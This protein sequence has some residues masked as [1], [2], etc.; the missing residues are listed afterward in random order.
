MENE[1]E[2]GKFLHGFLLIIN[3]II[4]AG[5]AVPL[6]I[7]LIFASDGYFGFS[8]TAGPL[9]WFLIVVPF[10]LGLMG[11][12]YSFKS[13]ESYTHKSYIDLLVLVIFLIPILYITFAP[14]AS[15]AYLN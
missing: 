14:L 6:G 13:K 9:S 5:Y 8:G 10:L 15:I 3:T 4:L 1:V 7:M 12:I 11:V 2:K